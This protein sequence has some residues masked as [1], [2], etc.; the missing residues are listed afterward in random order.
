MGGWLGMAT[1]SRELGPWDD[2]W[3]KVG[4]QPEKRA[5]LKAK[6]VRFAFADN[7]LSWWF[8][9]C[10]NDPTNPFG[11]WEHADVSTLFPD[12]HVLFLVCCRN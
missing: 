11:T 3:E 1:E 4:D 8:S 2:E 7:Q 12:Q 10:R 5:E 9:F 6:L